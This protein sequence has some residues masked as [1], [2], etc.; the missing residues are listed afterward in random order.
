MKNTE[1]FIGIVVHAE[2][3]KEADIRVKLLTAQGLQTFTATGAGKANAKLKS[4]VQL[5]IIAEFSVIGHK[6]V[7]AHIL[8]TNHGITK[9]IKRYYLACAICE[10]VAQITKYNVQ[11]TNAFLLTIE[12]LEKLNYPVENCRVIF[13]EYFSKLLKELGYDVESD[14][15]LNTA[16]ARHLDIKIPNTKYFL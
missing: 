2:K 10:V 6:L 5:F 16:Y 1:I 8:E 14:V 12:A 4:A 7:S 3:V 11:N 13:T 9:D 15:D